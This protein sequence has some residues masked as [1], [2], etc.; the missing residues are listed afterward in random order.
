MGSD[1]KDVQWKCEA[2]FDRRVVFDTVHVSCEGYHAPDDDYI[3][4]GSCGLEYRLKYTKQYMEEQE[5]AQGRQQSS[6]GSCAARGAADLEA[7][8]KELDN[9]FLFIV[10][11]GASVL[12]L[13]W[14]CNERKQE[15]AQPLQTAPP[16]DDFV[17]PRSSDAPRVGVPFAAPGFNASQP[18]TSPLYEATPAFASPAYGPSSADSGPGFVTGIAVGAL[19]GAAAAHLL[20]RRTRRGEYE[21]DP[22]S[23][24][25]GHQHS[26]NSAP[27]RFSDDHE[28]ATHKSTGYGS[29][30][31]R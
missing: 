18:Y 17:P 7:D 28:Y 25:D 13:I 27:T 8:D 30:S 4:E 24:H 6:H 10:L 3:L 16:M 11:A 29:S 12:V 15:N 14:F 1:G 31:R 22:N 23:E 19:G 26:D 5:K 2:E 20:N 21:T 9:L